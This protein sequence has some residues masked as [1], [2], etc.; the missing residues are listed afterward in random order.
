MMEAYHLE[1]TMNYRALV[2]PAAAA[3]GMAL[4]IGAALAQ[5]TPSRTAPT[6][7][8]P[9]VT[10]VGPAPAEDRSS[11]GAI[12]MEPRK[13]NPASVMGNVAGPAERVLSRDE[14]RKKREAEAKALRKR[15][16]GG[17]TEK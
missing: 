14:A 6:L 12:V 3:L 13:R 4:S 16:A 11:A 8:A 10:D 5:T 1:S 15:G 17:L 2:R 7:G 9:V